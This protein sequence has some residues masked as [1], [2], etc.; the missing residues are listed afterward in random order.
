LDAVDTTTYFETH[1]LPALTRSYPRHFTFY[2]AHPI[3]SIRWYDGKRTKIK[4]LMPAKPQIRRRTDSPWRTSNLK[5][6]MSVSR[7]ADRE[8]LSLL[9]DKHFRV[10][11]RNKREVIPLICPP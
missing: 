11:R 10:Y 4:N 6:Q 8:T 5:R 2:V 3:R 7:V 9:L 1:S